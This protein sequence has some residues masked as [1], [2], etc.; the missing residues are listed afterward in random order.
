MTVQN[1]HFEYVYEICLASS[2]MFVN[3]SPLEGQRTLHH[4]SDVL[5]TVVLVNP[6]EDSIASEVCIKADITSRRREADAD[7]VCLEQLPKSIN[8]LI[9]VM[10]NAF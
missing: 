6:S 7:I 9:I 8:V 10:Q 4:R 2:L 1:N 3:F 5:E